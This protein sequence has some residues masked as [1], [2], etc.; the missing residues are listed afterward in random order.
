MYNF[1]H[2]IRTEIII[3]R[4]DLGCINEECVLSRTN[5]NAK[6]SSTMLLPARRKRCAGNSHHRVSVCPCVTRPY[7]IK[8][9]K[10]RITQTTPSDSPANLVFR[11][12]NSLVDDLPSP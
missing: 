9:A 2:N 1:K 10:R 5:L 7:C 8:T 4:L 12:Q 6:Y 3:W 11:R